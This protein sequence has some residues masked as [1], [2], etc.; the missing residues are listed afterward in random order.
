MGLIAAAIQ[1]RYGAITDNR[2]PWFEDLRRW[3]NPPRA[4]PQPA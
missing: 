4:Q 1:R 2:D 3:T